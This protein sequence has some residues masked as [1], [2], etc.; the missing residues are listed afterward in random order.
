MFPSLLAS[1]PILPVSYRRLLHAAERWLNTLHPAHIHHSHR[2]AR[3]RRT[4]AELLDLRGRKR[5]PG[6]LR[7][8]RL[9]PVERDRRRRGRGAGHY[10][11]AQ[12]IIRRAHRAGP[13]WTRAEN[14]FSLWCNR[15]RRYHLHRSQLG[16]RHRTRLLRDAAS[17]RE[18]VL[19][20]RCDGV[21]DSLVHIS[22]VGN[23]PVI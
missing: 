16:R 15:R 22:D 11:P 7:Q 9:L 20:N 17:T 12:H 4:L 1:R 2:R 5:T 8:R 21:L 6:I 18:S 14:A 23:R 13:I 10:R 3:G 19:G